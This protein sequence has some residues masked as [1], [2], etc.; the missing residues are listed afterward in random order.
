MK[1]NFN[2]NIIE[3]IKGLFKP[4]KEDKIVEAVDNKLKEILEK[5]SSFSSLAEKMENEKLFQQGDI[6]NVRIECS[7]KSY[8]YSGIARRCLAVEPL[9]G[10]EPIYVIPKNS[11]SS[12]FTVLSK[13]TT[14]ESKIKTDKI[15]VPLFQ[16][17]SNPTIEIS[18]FNEYHG[19]KI[20]CSSVRDAIKEVH[21]QE[22]ANFLA[23]AEMAGS[24]NGVVSI[25]NGRETLA[26]FDF[27]ELKRKIE[28]ADLICS[29]F[30]M[31]NDDFNDVLTW[32]ANPNLDIVN[33]KEVIRTGLVATLFGADILVSNLVPKNTIYAFADPEF[34]GV[35][36]I[37][38]DA[39]VLDAHRIEL[40]KYGW[41]IRSEIGIGIL[42]Q[43]GIA[44][45]KKLL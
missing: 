12:G 22:D 26:L 30:V 25:Y 33:M 41:L 3:R 32:G 35:L 15:E 44:V 34:V 43:K 17:T 2:F 42:N 14:V 6:R 40:N 18:K 31:N 16:I 13:S 39:K 45:G 1:I 10:R 19:Y 23:A 36:P 11:S 4:K 7:N 9:N 28:S 21:K 37:K 20:A 29:T 8:G 24:L 38:E 27:I 5:F